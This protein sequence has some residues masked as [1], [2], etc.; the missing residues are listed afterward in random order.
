MFILRGKMNRTIHELLNYPIFSIQY[1][2]NNKSRILQG[3]VDYINHT[4]PFG[5]IKTKSSEILFIMRSILTTSSNVLLDL[6]L[7]LPF[8]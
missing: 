6:D 5:L 3:E 8:E 2:N 4:A 1:A 7:P